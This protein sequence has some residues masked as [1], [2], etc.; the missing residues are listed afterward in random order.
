[1]RVTQSGSPVKQT[2]TGSRHAAIPA[3]P[4]VKAPPPIELPGWDEPALELGQLFGYVVRMPTGRTAD[5]LAAARAYHELEAW[6]ATAGFPASTVSVPLRFIVGRTYLAVQVPTGPSTGGT[7]APR[8]WRYAA[9]NAPF[10]VDLV[11][12]LGAWPHA[13]TDGR[14][15][16]LLLEGTD[17]GN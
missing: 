17:A 5:D 4:R 11:T 3:R 13:G 7:P 9:P 1:M 8:V 10:P 15:L 14:A 16:E 2:A 12:H 6:L